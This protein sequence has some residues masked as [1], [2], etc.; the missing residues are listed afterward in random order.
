[1][2]D[3]RQQ[4][5]LYP[6]LAAFAPRPSVLTRA[7][8]ARGKFVMSMKR[9]PFFHDISTC[10]QVAMARALGGRGLRVLL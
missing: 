8:R 9:A 3:R 10:L 5:A 1:M 7:R 6:Q 2:K 4:K